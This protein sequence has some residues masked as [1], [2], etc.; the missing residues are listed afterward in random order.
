MPG[1]F[2]RERFEQ[3]S[4]P[5]NEW[6]NLLCSKCNNITLEQ[7]VTRFESFSS[8]ISRD[9]T[10]WTPDLSDG[11]FYGE[12][13]CPRM[14]CG[15]RHVV[16]GVWKMEWG[17]T[18]LEG[19]ED[20]PYLVGYSVRYMLPGLPLINLPVG[21]PSNLHNMIDSI[22]A[23]LL[24][25]Y[26]AAA[27]RIRSSIDCLL[28]NQRVRKHPTG[29]RKQKLTTHQRIEL[30]KE[31]N[32][33][34][35]EQLMA[36]KWIGN[37]GSHEIEALPLALVLDGIDHFAH[38]I[39]IIYDPRIKELNRRAARINRKGRKLRITDADLIR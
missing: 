7:E 34:A 29:N 12:L 20:D 33:E 17:P 23:V 4:G 16:A 9:S 30:F 37:V 21:V 18:G 31:N 14:G 32:K 10:D 19:S 35:A 39:E 2:D 28:D 25:D 24:T 27:N 13:V 5:F 1:L 15:N 6:P 11:Y 26:N 38:A 36:V 3:L 22:S 8:I